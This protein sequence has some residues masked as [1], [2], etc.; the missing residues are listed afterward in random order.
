MQT[1]HEQYLFAP[2]GRYDDN[3]SE[4][5]GFT[6]IELLVV[7]AI[8]A[9]LAALL[10]PAVHRALESGRRALCTSNLRQLAV[11]ANMFAGDHDEQYPLNTVGDPYNGYGWRASPRLLIEGEYVSYQ[12]FNCPSIPLT[13]PLGP[14]PI[15]EYYGDAFDEFAQLSGWSVGKSVRGSYEFVFSLDDKP[16]HRDERDPGDILMWDIASG[17]VHH[18]VIGHRF[19]PMVSHNADGGNVAYN[20]GH[21]VWQIASEWPPPWGNLPATQ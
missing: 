15:N 16:V 14:F 20:D 5:G 13:P 2:K 18:G 9:I 6:L 12:V 11:S 21:V 7:I 10:V 3:N 1:H 19:F 4:S 17:I 8:I